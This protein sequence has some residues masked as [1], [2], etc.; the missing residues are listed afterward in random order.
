MFD[1]RWSTGT[2]RSDRCFT[3]SAGVFV[4][5]NGSSPQS[6]WYA[7]TPSEYRSLRPST[8]RSPAD[9]SGLMNAGVPIA[10]PVAVRRALPSLIARAMPK[11]VTIGRLLARVEQ[12]VVGLD[13]AMHDAVRVRVR[14]RVAHF[15]Q[16]AAHLGG[17]ERAAIVNPLGERVAVDERHHEKDEPVLFVDAVDRDDARVRQL[18]RGLRLA[19]KTRA[20]LGAKRQFRAA[21]A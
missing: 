9:C 4:A 15:A 10:M 12:D 7:T 17:I 16:D 1:A 2:G 6:I 5:L 11:S 18:R 19:E 13:V 3:S 21:A 8:S 14:E 20:D